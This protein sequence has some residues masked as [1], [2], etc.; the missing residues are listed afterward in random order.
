VKTSKHLAQQTPKSKEERAA[1]RE[2]ELRQRVNLGTMAG[3]MVGTEFWKTRVRPMIEER[4]G[5]LEAGSAWHP[6]AGKSECEAIALGVSYNG[7]GITELNNLLAEIE[8][9]QMQG[10]E[11]GK[12]LDDISRRRK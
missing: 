8:A 5:L 9:A 6:G 2:K 11:A 4:I 3:L 10:V 1:E 12:K 7:G